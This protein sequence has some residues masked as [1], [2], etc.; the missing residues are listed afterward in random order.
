MSTD[1]SVS[2]R[3]SLRKASELPGPRG[4]PIVGMAPKIEHQRFHGQREDW[5]REY[6]GTFSFFLGP[7]RFIVF[8]DLDS[9]RDLLKRRPQVFFRGKRMTEIIKELGGK[10]DRCVRLRRCDAHIYKGGRAGAPT[11]RECTRYN[12]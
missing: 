4:L 1:R 12:I 5:Y 8:G 6:G 7:K 11:C 3:P 2:D 10:G 9:S